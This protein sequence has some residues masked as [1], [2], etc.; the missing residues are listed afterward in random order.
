M[1]LSRTFFYTATAAPIGTVV[2]PPNTPQRGPP[3][4]FHRSTEPP[5]RRF[6]ALFGPVLSS[7]HAI[8][9]A[10]QAAL[11]RSPGA[12]PFDDIRAATDA[13]R[14]EHHCWAYPFEDG[15]MLG[16]AAQ[17]IDADHV[18]ELG[19]A[20]GY[21]ACWWCTGNPRS[22]LD[23]IELDPVHVELARANFDR[24]GIGNRVRVLPGDFNDVLPTLAPRYGLAFFDAYAPTPEMFDLIQYVVQPGGV[25]V[26]ANL[27]LGGTEFRKNLRKNPAW[28][29][30]FIQ[31]TGFSVRLLDPA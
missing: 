4:A 15:R 10:L 30:R 13:H 22:H 11:N 9:D 14:A 18:L 3:N 24:V 5:P 1:G 6:Q 20:L 2:S 23:T 28:L 27:E 8:L 25:L 29:T 19:T 16:A 17:I 21:T 31:D 26:T 12:D 7:P